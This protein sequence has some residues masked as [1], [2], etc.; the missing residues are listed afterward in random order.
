VKTVPV[1]LF[2]GRGYFI[3][4][5]APLRDLGRNLRPFGLSRT[6]LVV[7]DRPVARRY[8]PVLLRGLRQAGFRPALA[9]VPSGEAAKNLD[10]VRR[11]YREGVTARLDRKSAVVALGGGVVGDMAGFMA[12]T[13]LRGLPLI[14]CPTTLLSMVDSSIGGKTGVDLP[15]GK[16]LVGAFW[17]PKLV[18]MDLSVLKTLP[19]REWRTGIAEVVKYGVIADPDILALLE[20]VDLAVFRRRPDL[21]EDIV[22]RSA[23]I[24]ARV[25]AQDE[26]DT[27]GQREMLNLGHTFGHAIEAVTRYGRYTHGEAIAVGMCAAARL[28]GRMGIFSKE[29]VPRLEALLKRWGLPCRVRR[30]L[31]RRKI[32]AAMARDKKAYAGRFRFVVPVRWGEAKSLSDFPRSALDKVLTEIGI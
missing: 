22:A 8:A 18:W 24:K 6:A 26:N 20:K 10:T 3:K 30:P 5:G 7:S 17:Q 21:V 14:Q 29:N 4:V 13:Y 28:A 31:P 16:N 12:A 2:A 9:V 1:K 19:P 32:L 23:R 15:E 27:R 11:L 25:V